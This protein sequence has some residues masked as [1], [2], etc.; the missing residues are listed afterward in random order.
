MS[1]STFG[2]E[3]PDTLLRMNALG[4]IF[5]DMGVL[6]RALSLHETVLA[7]RRKTLGENHAE[8]VTTMASLVE[9][10][11]RKGRLDE[12]VNLRELV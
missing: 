1:L 11:Y 2:D 8:T 4:S 5:R 3:H 9:T 10:L 6:D 7:L 12:S